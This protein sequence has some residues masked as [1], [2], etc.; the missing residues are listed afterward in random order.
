[1]FTGQSLPAD[2]SAAVA[3]FERTLA[4]L[5]DW[6][7]LVVI[8]VLSLGIARLVQV[9]G[10]RAIARI[11]RRIDGEVDD[12]VLR[13]VHPA[14]YLTVVLVGAYLA[15]EPIGLTGALD[16]Q[17]AATIL[18]VLTVVWAVTLVR[19]GRK[20]SHELTTTEVVDQSVVPIFQNV[21]SF[22][23]LSVSGF[24]LLTY[25]NIDVTPLLASAG[26]LGIVIGLA[27]RDTIANFFGSIALYFD[28]T[29]RV[30]DYIVL[31]SGERGRVEDVSIRST[32]IRTRDDI[33]VTIPNARLNSATVVN[34]SAPDRER[35]IRIPV[36]VA[37]GSDLDH[38]EETL[39]GVAEAES[40]VQ[41]RPTP[42]VRVRGFGDSSV[43]VEL[44][45][46]IR[47]PVLRGRATHLLNKGV[48]AAFVETGIEIPFPQRDVHVVDGA[49]TLGDAGAGRAAEG[50]EALGDDD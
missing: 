22:L 42:R 33:L 10:D 38:V 17:V 8:V 16:V 21:W 12:I 35:R 11:T 27:A 13:G 25:W 1:M 28:G 47:D 3:E 5:P 37:Y 23:V 7:A 40:L 14:G 4:A 18:S 48:Y 46:W 29:Y 50:A 19:V 45:C 36:G 20:V 32:V 30:G 44:L 2:P 9:G 15:R 34:E 24:L 26:I 49:A 43:D 31:E 6:Q 39:L 41:E